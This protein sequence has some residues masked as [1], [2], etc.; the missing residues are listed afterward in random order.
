MTVQEEC[1]VALGDS[2]LNAVERNR[3]WQAELTRSKALRSDFQHRQEIGESLQFAQ[4]ARSFSIFTTAL[5]EQFRNFDQRLA[6]EIVATVA[7]GGGQVE[8]AAVLRREIDA[9]MKQ[10]ILSTR[11]ALRDMKISA[12]R[13]DVEPVG[14]AVAVPAVMPVGVA[15]PQ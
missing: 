13:P 15:Q 3:K 7:A 9:A 1:V 8:V 10:T 4:A 6:A 5:D 14:A 11:R 2:E 12:Q